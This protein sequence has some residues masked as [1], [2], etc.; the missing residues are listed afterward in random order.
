[1][2]QS[3]DTSPDAER[4]QI[5]LLRKAGLRRRLRLA[6]SLSDSAIKLSRR[7][8]RRANPLL[9]EQE[10]RLRF[11]ALHYGERMEKAVRRH[12]ERLQR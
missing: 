6:L 7:A 11:V 4:V 1:M 2:L 3:A 10:V 8:I 12:L 9:S 5:A